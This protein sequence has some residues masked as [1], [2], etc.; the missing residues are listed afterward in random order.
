MKYQESDIVTKIPNLEQREQNFFDNMVKDI[1]DR[2]DS[3][4]SDKNMKKEEFK[5]TLM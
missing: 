4:K 1:E 5:I 2:K 3:R